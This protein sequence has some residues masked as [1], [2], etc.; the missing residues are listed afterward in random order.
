MTF[1]KLL[2]ELL[3]PIINNRISFPQKSE[4]GWFGDYDSWDSAQKE[5][6]GYDDEAIL[7]K[8]KDALLNVKNGQAVYE[9]DSV[10][11]DKIQYA[12]PVLAGLLRAAAENQNQLSVLDFGGSLGSSY[13]QNRSFLGG[14]NCLNWS[15]VE[16]MHFVKCGR[17]YFEN[18]E[19]NFYK[20]FHQCI[21]EKHPDV[22]IASS[23]LQYL[24]KPYEIL[25]TFANS[26]I[27]WIIFDR[28]AFLI[29]N[30]KDRLTIQIVPP[31]IYNASYPAWFFNK[32]RFLQSFSDSYDLIAEFD[33]MD[34][35]NI[36]SQFKGFLFKLS[37]Y[38]A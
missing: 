21:D 3:P 18:D 29:S 17:H 35:A 7:S 30:D 36:P 27:K 38:H 11:F 25:Q 32:Q 28:T 19:L 20:N 9:R 13:F 22:L 1:K 23:V 4:Y 26:K 16:Q 34:K 6:G 14:L 15:I 24:E 2:K 8:V 10:I 12:W 5:C 31:D 33:C 37:G